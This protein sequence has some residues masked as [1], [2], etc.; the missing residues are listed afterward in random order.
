V[1]RMTW[2]DVSEG[3]IRV[4]QQKTQRKLTIPLHR[5]LLDILTVSNR[6]HLTII[7][8]GYGRPFTVDGFSLWLR[9]GSPLPGCRSSV[10]RMGYARQLGGVWRKRDA[11][12]TRSWQCSAIRPFRKRSAILAKLIRGG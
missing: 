2:A 10:N 4:V 3:T 11:A 6:N 5:D 1:H 7:N 8:T 9:D 12:R